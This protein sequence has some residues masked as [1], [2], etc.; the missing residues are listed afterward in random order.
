[1]QYS[2]QRRRFFR[3]QFPYGKW[4]PV[5]L[6]IAEGCDLPTPP[7][8]NGRWIEDSSLDVQRWQMDS[9][10]RAAERLVDERGYAQFEV[11]GGSFKLP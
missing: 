8:E 4:S 3:Q 2:G 11:S 7:H 9:Q 1:M 10:F 5:F 6:I